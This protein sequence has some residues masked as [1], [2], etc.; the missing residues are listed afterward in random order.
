MGYTVQSVRDGKLKRGGTNGYTCTPAE[1]RN[2]SDTNGTR[3][4]IWVWKPGVA[5]LAVSK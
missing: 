2:Y 4:G 5:L 1:E 3:I